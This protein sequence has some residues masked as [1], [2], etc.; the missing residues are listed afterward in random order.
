MKRRAGGLVWL[1][2]LCAG[3]WARGAGELGVAQYLASHAAA[4]PAGGL[5]ADLPSGFLAAAGPRLYL[6]GEVHGAATNNDADLTLLKTLQRTAGVRTYLCEVS[7]AQSWYLNRF[8]EKGNA[9][10]LDLVFTQL[11]GRTVDG[12]QEKRAFWENLR[13][14]NESLPAAERITIVGVDFE[15]FSGISLAFLR[16]ELG[17]LGE[18]GAVEKVAREV[19]ANR[20]K[21]LAALGPDR[22]FG[23]EQALRNLRDRT[24]ASTFHGPAFDEFRDQALSGNFLAMTGRLPP[25]SIYG[26]VGFAHVAQHRYDGSYWLSYYLD[27][28]PSPWAGRV[29]GIWPLYV[30]SRRL[31]LL[32]GHYEI[33]DVDD[34]L[35]PTGPFEAAA[36]S[37]L[38]LF[39]LGAPGSPFRHRLI[40]PARA[41]GGATT[42]YFQ[43]VLL[44]KN[45]PPARPWIPPPP[46]H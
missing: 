5:P 12:S 28:R 46:K 15:R 9:T 37:D 36:S 18:S 44:L 42:E 23:V 29:I 2:L 25:G 38:T 20:P 7:Y 10:L 33:V 30:H 6:L 14:W 3:P 11:R 17:P 27:R 1:A 13:R 21:F 26:R 43:Y 32:N 40:V 8:W 31:A 35:G 45:T 24:R 22:L 16:Q 4:L 34:E 41:E 39:Q 19:A